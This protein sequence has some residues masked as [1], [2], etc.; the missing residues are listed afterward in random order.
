MNANLSISGG[1]GTGG[2]FYVSCDYFV[3]VYDY[4]HEHP[5]NWRRQG[6]PTTTPPGTLHFNYVWDST[7][8]KAYPAFNPIS[9]LFHCTMR[10][11]VGYT[12]DGTNYVQAGN[13]YFQPFS[14]PF[15]LDW[16]PLLRNPSTPGFS[17]TRI[18]PVPDDHT[19]G[20]LIQA[21]DRLHNST[22]T[23][24]FG[25]QFYQFNCDVCM[26]PDE[27]QTLDGPITIRSSVELIPPYINN[28]Q[29][30]LSKSG[31]W[32]YFPLGESI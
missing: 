21:Y 24:F 23:T 28:W 4:D 29:Y 3:S 20:E 11:W 16:G 1:P 15:G 2:Q 18:Q 26:N 31:F 17:A 30:T 5:I 32:S 22:P 7:S 13:K 25:T 14:P 27:W 10:E 8:G 12:G 19:K 9:D 6:D